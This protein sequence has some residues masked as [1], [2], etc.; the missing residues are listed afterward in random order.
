MVAVSV[1][2]APDSG[3]TAPMALCPCSLFP[4]RGSSVHSSR[5]QGFLGI[6]ALW[7][8]SVFLESKVYDYL[9]FSSSFIPVVIKFPILYSLIFFT[10]LIVL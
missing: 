7:M 8:L 1:G 5:V 10:I 3:L 6:Y 4:T 9:C 2:V